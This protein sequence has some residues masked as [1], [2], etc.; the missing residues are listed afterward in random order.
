MAVPE[1]RQVQPHETT[2]VIDLTRALETLRS[3]ERVR[4]P[5]SITKPDEVIA[6]EGERFTD[7]YFTGE[8]AVRYMTALAI[9]RDR[10]KREL[11]MMGEKEREEKK[12]IE[13]KL[14]DEILKVENDGSLEEFIKQK[15]SSEGDNEFVKQI[16]YEPNQ[17]DITPLMKQVKCTC[18]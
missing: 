12:E 2:L 9:R 5:P 7:G 18:V 16:R 3:H 8:D 6:Q 10:I 4:Q 1:G 17:L 11:E 13:R 15:R 14:R